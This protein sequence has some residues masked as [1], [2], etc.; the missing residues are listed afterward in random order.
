[1]KK[2][3]KKSKLWTLILIVSVCYFAY[4]IYNQQN[5]ISGKEI[6]YAQLQ[7]DIYAAKIKNEQLLHQKSLINTNEFAEKIAREKLGYVKDGEKVYVDT[8]R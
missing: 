5:Y 8:N 7:K 3:Q 2:K 4:T 6:H 1:M